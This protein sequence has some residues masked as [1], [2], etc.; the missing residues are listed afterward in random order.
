MKVFNLLDYVKREKSSLDNVFG[1]TSGVI[2]NCNVHPFIDIPTGKPIKGSKGE[3]Y[4]NGG[5]APFTGSAGL[6][7][8]F[9]TAVADD[10]LLSVLH[11][12]FP[13]S[14]GQK[15]ETEGSG[16]PD[17][18]IQV[19]KRHKIFSME[20]GDQ[21]IRSKLLVTGTNKQEGGDEAGSWWKK[22]QDYAKEYRDKKK[23][24][25][26]LET[27]WLVP[28]V[29]EDGSVKDEKYKMLPM[30]AAS[31]DSLSELPI[32]KVDDMFLANEVGTSKT[33][34]EAMA[35]GSAK[36]QLIRQIPIFASEY[37][38]Y[39]VVTAHLGEGLNLDP[40]S[41]PTTLLADLKKLKFKHT[42]EKF[43]F[44]TNNC[45][46]NVGTRK[47]HDGQRYM[48]YPYN[49]TD[50]L[51]KDDPDLVR[52]RTCNARG[53]NGPSGASLFYAASMQHGIDWDLTSWIYI[54]E[55]EMERNVGLETSGNGTYNLT[56]LPTVKVTRNTLRKTLRENLIFRQ[57]LRMTIT[58]VQVQD[59]WDTSIWKWRASPQEVNDMIE[60]RGLDRDLLFSTREYWTYRECE[61]IPGSPHLNVMTGLMLM[62][63][64]HH[65][66]YLPYW[67]NDAVKAKAKE[68]AKAKEK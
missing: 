4:I 25:K 22:W 19:S 13:F 33:N 31:I 44:L 37:K 14:E 5:F 50:L 34:T 66:D 28:S 65:E 15:F 67:Y 53:K 20:G 30:F 1:R 21:Y 32:K 3:W 27:P 47:I 52:I 12:F 63:M 61:D 45:F 36:T 46:I 18:L 8:T 55:R 40:M 59:F 56:I 41:P 39:F 54:R 64:V 6:P 60:K 29:K 49:P 58:M 26:K 38:I 57:A 62:Y 23:R 10:F 9:K 7:N 68:E 35:G 24:P 51:K 48:E 42:P 16:T 2:P 11:N 17:R 43:T